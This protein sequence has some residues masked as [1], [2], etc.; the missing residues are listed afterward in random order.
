MCCHLNGFAPLGW[1]INS[2]ISIPEVTKGWQGS[3]YLPVDTQ[4]CCHYTNLR[5]SGDLQVRTF[6]M[7]RSPRAQLHKDGNKKQKTKKKG[8]YRRGSYWLRRSAGPPP[9]PTLLN[10]IPCHRLGKINLS[11]K[12]R[13]ETLKCCNTFWSCKWNE[14]LMNSTNSPWFNKWQICP[15]LIKKK[16]K[17]PS[18]DRSINLSAWSYP[19]VWKHFNYLPS[20]K[21]KRLLSGNLIRYEWR[22]G[23]LI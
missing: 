10:P 2:V 7:R 22:N 15:L 20:K 3:L 6:K 19:R 12:L 11:H 4:F 14:V 23:I 18:R 21:K 9:T 13:E 17:R 16:R 8:G 5:W 1:C